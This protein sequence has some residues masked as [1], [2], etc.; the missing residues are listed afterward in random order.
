MQP[1]GYPGNQLPNSQYNPI[2]FLSN[3]YQESN[4]GQNAGNWQ[5][6]DWRG[7]YKSYLENQVF[8]SLEMARDFRAQDYEQ[9]LGGFNAHQ[10]MVLN[11]A[12]IRAMEAQQQRE[13]VALG[14]GQQ[15]WESEFGEA[16]RQFDIGA[17]L[18]REGYRS[19]EDIASG[20]YASQERIA[21]GQNQA[22]MAR[23]MQQLGFGRE[24]L[25]Q[26]ESQFGR[27]LGFQR[28]ELG[29]QE[30]QFGRTLGFQQRELEQQA[31][32]FGRSATLAE[33]ESG[34]R[35]GSGGLEEQRIAQTQE[36]GAAT[37]ALQDRM[38]ERQLRT[39]Q[40]TERRRLEL[41]KE[42]IRS[43]ESQSRWAQHG[44]ANRPNVT[45]ARNW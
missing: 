44:R 1:P 14:L 31:A 32:Q 12:S 37:R 5:T 23:L 41:E 11:Q 2:D 45:W 25:A 35:Y 28:E 24:E 39:Q 38:Q 40:D 29:Q 3:V 7:P 9:R 43:Q 13:N 22:A 15:R 42:R 17:G 16:G 21:G 36:E 10:A 34:R 33:Q 8:P 19:Q 4:W 26:A 30:S 27:Q 20:G 6:D 18:T